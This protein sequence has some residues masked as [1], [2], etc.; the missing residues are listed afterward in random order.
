MKKVVLN[1]GCG[2]VRI[3][4]SIGVDQVKIDDYVDIVHNLD[5][6]P[7]PFENNSVDEIHFYH[8]LEHL[9]D[10]I[11]KLEEIYRILKP[12]GVLYMRVPHFSSMGAFTDLTHIRP[13]GYSSFDCFEKEHY[14]HFYTTVEFKIIRKEIK[15]FGLY[16]NNGLYEKYVHK[17]QSPFFIRPF[18]RLINFLIILSPF[19]F[20]RVWCY[21]VGGATEV[22]L[23][24]KKI[25]K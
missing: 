3:P 4:K 6:V 25:A 1:L 21:W 8:V 14:H 9:H 22:V 7:Y 5:V 2:K 10:P 17:N 24:L 11:R 13:F 18:I 12:G 23:E 20:E 16:P 15:Y 19:F